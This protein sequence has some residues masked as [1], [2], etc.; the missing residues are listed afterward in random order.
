[1]TTTRKSLSEWIVTALPGVLPWMIA[2]L[3]S[4]YTGYNTGLTKIAA[5]EAK[6][7]DRDEHDKRVRDFNTCIVRRM[8]WIGAGAKGDAPCALEVPE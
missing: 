3:A 4:A 8:D 6:D 7:H 2:L 1:M 5:L